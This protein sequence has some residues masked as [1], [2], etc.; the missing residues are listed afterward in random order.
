MADKLNIAASNKLLKLLEEPPEKPFYSDFREWRGH[1]T[2]HSPCCQILQFNG[3]SE[4]VIA[5]ALVEREKIDLKSA[6]KIAHQAQGN[7]NL[8]IYCMMMT[9]IHLKNGLL[10]GY[11]QL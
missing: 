1:H 8:Y 2:N 11:V 3:L 5:E 4:A 7:Y 6:T 9:N 10:P